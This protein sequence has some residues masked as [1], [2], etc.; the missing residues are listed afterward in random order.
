M[1]NERPGKVAGLY[2]SWHRCIVDGRDHA[3][4]DEQFLVGMQAGQGRYE[5]V[6]GHV[7]DVES[8]LFPPGSPCARCH[9]CLAERASLRD[10]AERMVRS[11]HRKRSIWRRLFARSCTQ[12][13]TE[14]GRPP[15]EPA[16]AGRHTPRDVQ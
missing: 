5:A 10:V 3:V 2:L 8:L 7:L 6:C 4:T 1:S 16:P 15:T 11:R 9:T 14:A 13:P 12:V